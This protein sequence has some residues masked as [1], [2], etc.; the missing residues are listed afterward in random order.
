[1]LR[2]KINNRFLKEREYIIDT[3]F[4]DFLGIPYRI[5]YH[6]KDDTLLVLD[7]D[8]KITIKDAFFSHIDESKGYLEMKNLPVN[9]ETFQD[10]RFSEEPLV[11][12][13]GSG[14]ITVHPGAIREIECGIDLLASSFFMLTR[15]EE[16]VH[17]ARDEHDRFP[18]VESTAAKNNFLPRPIVN[19]YLELLRNMLKYSGCKGSRQT[20]QFKIFP[21]HDVDHIRYWKNPGQLVRLMGG[22]L[23]R[24]K[25]LQLAYNHAREYF[26][27][28]TGKQK[29]PYDT[30]DD[31]MDLSE[32]AGLRS[33]FFFMAGGTSQYDRRYPVKSGA[34][35]ERIRRIQRRGHEIGIHPGYNTY[36]NPVLLEH[37][38]KRL[39]EVSPMKITGG[40]QHYL[41]FKTPWTW[42]IWADV[43]LEW[44]STMAYP[45]LQ[46]FRCGTCFDFTPFNILTREKIN[47]REY[48][49]I[50][51]DINLKK[52]S[53][54][55]IFETLQGLKSCCQKHNGNFVVLWHNSNVSNPLFN[56]YQSIYRDLIK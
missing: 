18:G 3:I 9:I 35:K 6:K 19:E 10:S 45:D 12:L 22:D 1:M 46:G 39:Q 25:N 13:Y 47:I 43:H 26:R 55:R 27:V 48:P 41:R 15:W 2:I 11:V 53:S 34:V 32:Q 16:Y 56:E 5:E 7:N 52:D 44:D 20:R 8:R 17:P 4:N 37:E 14:K 50:A 49:L 30:F 21:T 51:S 29:D 24:R 38:L 33:Y 40:R 23:L 42:Q 31:L 36:E 54:T 28:K